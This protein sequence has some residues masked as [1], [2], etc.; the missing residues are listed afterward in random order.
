MRDYR[1]KMRRYRLEEQRYDELRQYC[2]QGATEEIKS[3][4]KMTG[5]GCLAHWIELHVCHGWKWARLEANGIPCAMDTF[6]LYR[7]MFYWHL[8]KVLRENGADSDARG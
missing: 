1:K 3:A 8:D 5:G 7:A 6:R 4:L 2:R